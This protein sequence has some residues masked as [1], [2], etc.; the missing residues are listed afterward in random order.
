MR[1]LLL[2]SLLFVLCGFCVSVPVKYTVCSERGA[3]L[4]LTSVEA[5]EWPPHKGDT[6]NVTLAGILDKTETKGEY[7][8]R[9]RVSGFPL[10]PETGDIA[11]FYPL[12]WLKGDLAFSFTS[13]I[14]SSSPSGSYNIEISARDQDNEQIWCVDLA[15]QLATAIQQVGDA[16]AMSHAATPKMKALID[17]ARAARHSNRQRHK[18]N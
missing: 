18:T 4:N 5:N 15:F 8:V 11:Q 12:P 14:P 7:T 6:L 1:A 3:H 17:G 10:P 2:L 13:E 16:I 9:I